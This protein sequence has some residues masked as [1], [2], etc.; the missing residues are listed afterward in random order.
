MKKSMNRVKDCSGKPAAGPELVEGLGEDLQRKAWRRA[1][2]AS[3]AGRRN[4]QKG[5]DSS[6]LQNM[7]Q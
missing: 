1:S 7:M 2:R 3:A 5:I 4:A 6:I